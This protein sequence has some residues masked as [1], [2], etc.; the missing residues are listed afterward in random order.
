MV[1]M[2]LVMLAQSAGPTLPPPVPKTADEII[3]GMVPEKIGVCGRSE[4]EQFPC[5]IAVKPDDPDAFYL[6]I[7]DGDGKMLEIIRHDNNKGTQTTIWK[8]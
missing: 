5:V 7:F 2:A 8:K 6:V 1:I 4:T 3:E